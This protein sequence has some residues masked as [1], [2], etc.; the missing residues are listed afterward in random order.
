[1]ESRLEFQNDFAGG[2]DNDRSL[3]RS[4]RVCDK[5][6]CAELEV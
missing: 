3:M 5:Q 2:S 4:R 1:M 6:I